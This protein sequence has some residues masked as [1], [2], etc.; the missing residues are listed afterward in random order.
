MS[1]TWYN[2][3]AGRGSVGHGFVLEEDADRAGGL[4]VGE[5]VADDQPIVRAL[6]GAG[7]GG[8]GDPGVADVAR[9]MEL[10]PGV[11]LESRAEEGLGIEGFRPSGVRPPSPPRWHRNGQVRP[12]AAGGVGFT[13]L[14]RLTHMA[15]SSPRFVGRS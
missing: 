6:S 7:S 12:V 10:G 5:P 11:G 9:K 15:L 1:R 4:P 3:T 8:A 2:S 13:I 14:L